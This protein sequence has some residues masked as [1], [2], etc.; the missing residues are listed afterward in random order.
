MRFDNFSDPIDYHGC[1]EN[2]LFRLFTLAYVLEFYDRTIT[3]IRSLH[4]NH[5]IIDGL[6]FDV[7]LML[8]NINREHLS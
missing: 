8:C 1:F 2:L 5:E 3:F 7:L 6:V 4:P